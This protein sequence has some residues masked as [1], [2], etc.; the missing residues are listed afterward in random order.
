MTDQYG[1]LVSGMSVTFAAPGSLASGSFS[2][3]TGTI[4]G[5]TNSVGQVSET[6][7]AN[8]IAGSNY[9]VTATATGEP[10]PPASR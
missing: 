10:A 1:N 7:T 6:F 9:T 5:T 2:N 3:S 4:I 8:T